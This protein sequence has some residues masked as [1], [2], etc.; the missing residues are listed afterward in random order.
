MIAQVRADIAT[1][2]GT[3]IPALTM[4]VH[5]GRFSLDELRRFAVRAPAGIVVA[6][7]SRGSTMAGTLRVLDVDWAVFIISR[8]TSAT[9]RDTQAHNLAYSVAAE[10]HLNRWDNDYAHAPKAV[11]WDNLYSGDL[12]KS[13]IA[14]HVV[15]WTQGVELNT[16]TDPVEAFE[17]MDVTWAMEESTQPSDASDIVEIPQ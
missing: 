13:G 16:I 8:G 9:G 7:G 14:I 1:A 10:I 2:L 4:G 17:D 11:A 3:A 5:P 6:E 15:T 12:D